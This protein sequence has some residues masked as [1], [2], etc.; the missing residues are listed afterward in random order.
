MGG[1]YCE[2]CNYFYQP[3]LSK[4]DGECTDPSKIVYVKYGDRI[5]SEPSVHKTNECCNH[6]SL[7]DNQPLNHERAKPN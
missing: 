6:T 2:T 3:P 1:P 5:S 7:T 4:D